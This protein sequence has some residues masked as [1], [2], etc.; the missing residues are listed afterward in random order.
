MVALLRSPTTHAVAALSITQIIGWGTTFNLPAVLGPA[1]GPD[2]GLPLSAIM[3]GPTVML[4]IMAVISWH[5]ACQFEEHG[6]RPIMA[7]GSL[8]G[9]F[10]LLLLSQSGNATV[11]FLAWFMLGFAGAGM[12]TT[13]AQIAVKEVAGAQAR[14][15]LGALM[16]A[17][18]LTST[19]MWPVTGLLQAQWGWRATTLL[20]AALLLLVCLP[21]HWLALARHTH[22]SGRGSAAAGSGDIDIARFTLLAA[23]FALNGFVTWGFSLTIIILF[24]ARGLSQAEA[25]AAAALIGIA[26]LTAR[27]VD[28]LGSRRWSGLATALVT[29]LLFPA[30]FAFLLLAGGFTT[31][32]L[33]A[34]LYGLAGGAT[35]VARATL[36]LEIFPSEAYARASARLAVPLNLSFAAAPPVFAAIISSAGA[37]SALLLALGLSSAA[38]ACLLALFL[39]QRRIA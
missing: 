30:S 7:F 12:L 9:A 14:Q 2:I 25:I 1:M 11:Y 16:L 31:A 29:S 18:G 22:H 3:A 15:A 38:L 5:L 4:V 26:Q 34:C 8:I 33:F 36:P 13:A 17:G 28:F 37:E 32:A 24:Q 23:T 27:F 19:L 10:G 39:L 21:L 20:Y 6:A 35:A